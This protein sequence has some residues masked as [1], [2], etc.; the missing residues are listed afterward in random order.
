M[1]AS[2]GPHSTPFG[3]GDVIAIQLDPTGYPIPNVV[4]AQAFI[5][6][7]KMIADM[8]V[9]LAW[10]HHMDQHHSHQEGS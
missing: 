5:A 10:L 7:M 2:T 4:A 1:A 8:L 6:G 9:Y 3:D